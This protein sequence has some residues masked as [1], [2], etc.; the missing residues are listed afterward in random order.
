VYAQAD[1]AALRDT[2][3]Q[4]WA[5]LTASPP[6]VTAGGEMPGQTAIDVEHPFDTLEPQEAAS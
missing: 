2:A 5:D 4:V 3:E 6:A 1:P